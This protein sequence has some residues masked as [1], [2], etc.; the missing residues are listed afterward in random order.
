MLAEIDESLARPFPMRRLLQGDVGA[1]KT[2][3]A[4]GALLRAVDAGRQGALMAP[5]ETLAQQHLRTAERLL[6]DVGVELWYLAGEVP[7]RER[8]AREARIASGE[9]GIAVGTHAL[10]NATFPSLAVT[11]VDEQHRFGVGQRMAVG[12]DLAF[13]SHVLHMTATPIPRSLALTAF[14]DLDVSILDEVPAGRKRVSTSII[15]EDR[16]EDCYR[17]LVGQIGAGHQAYVVCPLVDDSDTIVARAAEAEAARLASGP[18]AG[19][20]VGCM[21]GQLPPRRRR[22]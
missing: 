13:S 21:H 22:T 11:V 10:L 9:P 3:V 14:G 15:P 19:V 16:R 4:L 1:G 6:A 8:R 18:L 7:A 5:T 17:W 12:G 20:S 2:A